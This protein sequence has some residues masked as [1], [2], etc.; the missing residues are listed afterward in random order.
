MIKVAATP[1]RSR[2]LSRQSVADR[3]HEPTKALFEFLDVA[4]EE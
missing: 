4:P 3:D 2:S 1:T